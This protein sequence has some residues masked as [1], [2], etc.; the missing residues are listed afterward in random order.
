M[1]KA[2]TPE[3]QTT[4]ICPK[5]GNDKLVLLTSLQLKICPDCNTQIPW[6]LDEGQKPLFG[7]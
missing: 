7:K 1:P 2:V 6:Y 4:K 5:C 3:R